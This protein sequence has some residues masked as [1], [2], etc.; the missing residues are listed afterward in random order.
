[1]VQGPINF[2]TAWK[3]ISK[4]WQQEM[5]FEKVEISGNEMLGNQVLNM[6]SVMA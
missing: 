3:L 1:V 4:S 2:E 6:V 5:V